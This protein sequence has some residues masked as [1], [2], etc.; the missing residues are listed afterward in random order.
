MSLSF[1]SISKI[2]IF[3]KS[4]FPEGAAISGPLPALEEGGDR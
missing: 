2:A 4:Y 3:I 1:L